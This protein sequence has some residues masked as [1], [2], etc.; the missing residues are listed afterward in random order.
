MIVCCN[1]LTAGSGAAKITVLDI[2]HP[3]LV[4]INIDLINTNLNLKLEY[5][6]APEIKQD[7]G[8]SP[9]LF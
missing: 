6:L 1:M 9:V 2:I 5:S 4:W 7:N 8:G 3:I